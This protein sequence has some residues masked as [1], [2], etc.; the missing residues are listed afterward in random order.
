MCIGRVHENSL[1]TQVH[2]VSL[3]TRAIEAYTRFDIEANTHLD[4]RWPDTVKS[5][6]LERASSSSSF[7]L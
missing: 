1:S 4:R 6:F 5:E 2:D 7:S 3:S